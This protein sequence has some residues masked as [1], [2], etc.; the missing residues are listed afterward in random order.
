MNYDIISYMRMENAEHPA[1]AFSV[2]IMPQGEDIAINVSEVVN[3]QE[4]DA[5]YL[6]TKAL[7]KELCAFIEK[8]G[9]LAWK[10]CAP[11]DP[12]PHILKTV[13]IL[14]QGGEMLMVGNPQELP[15]DGE[16]KLDALEKE[17]RS[18]IARSKKA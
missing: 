7:W 6:T 10:P 8:E 11:G 17:I 4:K 15:P 2:T 9:F 1:E 5:D 16:K 3:K 13:T 12:T 18:I 14:P